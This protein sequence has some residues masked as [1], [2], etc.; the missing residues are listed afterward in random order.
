[1]PP[2]WASSRG[3]T[4]CARAQKSGKRA[5]ARRPLR[6]ID[7]PLRTIALCVR[8]R[9]LR[10]SCAAR[11]VLAGAQYHAVI[12]AAFT[13]VSLN[14]TAFLL[15]F[16]TITIHLTPEKHVWPAAALA[17]TLVYFV[18]PFDWMSE[19]KDAKQRQS[20]F[21]CVLRV[22]GAP[23]STASFA[24]SF[25][26]DVLT[27]MPKCFSDLLYSACAF[28]TGEIWSAGVWDASAHAYSRPAFCAD[29]NPNYH[30]VHVAL[31]VLPFWLRLMQC[32]RGLRDG[33]HPRR[34]L[35]NGAK[36]CGS[37]AVVLLS[38]GGRTEVWL[39]AST[40]ST[41][42][43]YTWDVT[44]DWG[45]G[46]RAV[47]RALHGELMEAE[48]ADGAA[49]G[50]LDGALENGPD[51]AAAGMAAG[52]SSGAGASSAGGSHPWLRAD[53]A[54]PAWAYYAAM[55]LNAIARLGWAIYICV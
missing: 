24:H 9:A 51:G 7:H 49:D 20:L 34:Q 41:L 11:P 31:S 23:L 15:F 33:R 42:L 43:A 4:T 32:A 37:I 47:R 46:P 17:G 22:L 28:G 50:T 48:A 54:Y 39:L 21:R 30:A 1:M 3:S 2:S 36:Y 35:A 13:L 27:S 18:S 45:L 40:L 19:W 6:A 44:V 14:F 26:A 16:L 38:L 12:R 29:A 53:R 8:S 5:C 10:G 52:A 55:G 25:V